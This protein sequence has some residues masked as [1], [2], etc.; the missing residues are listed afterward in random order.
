MIEGNKPALLDSFM[1]SLVAPL[2]LTAELCF[3]L[4]QM[5]TLEEQLH[6][7][8]GPISEELNVISKEKPY[9]KM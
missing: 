3:M 8:P 5:P 6:N 2:F 1:Q 4:G 9:D 7:T